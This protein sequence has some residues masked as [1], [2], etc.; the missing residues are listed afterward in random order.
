MIFTVG[1]VEGSIARQVALRPGNGIIV[2][3]LSA[4][5]DHH[6]VRGDLACIQGDAVTCRAGFRYDDHPTDPV[7]GVLRAHSC[8]CSQCSEPDG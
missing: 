1:G 3:S 6:L 7:D 2:V 8:G 4:L 5:R